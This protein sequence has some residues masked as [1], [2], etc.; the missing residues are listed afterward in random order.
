MTSWS[1]PVLPGAVLAARLSEDS[2]RSVM[3][4]EAGADYPAVEQTPSDLLHTWISAGPHDWGLVAKATADREIV[5]P[6][7]QG[8]RRMLRG[9]RAYRAARYA[10]GFRRMGRL[11]QLRS[12]VFRRCCR[13]I[14]SSK[15]IATRRAIFTAPAGRSG[16]NVRAPRPGSRSIAPFMRPRRELG[17]AEVWDHNDPRSTGVGPWPRNRRDG[18]RISTA[19]GYLNPARHRLNLT[20]AAFQP[21]P[22]A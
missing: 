20:D 21:I 17:Y 1:V 16:S 6:A 2:D 18:I 5:V 10:R 15:T 3:L 13:F 9:Q 19:I 8:H 22:I 12:G 4:L 14:A 7:R 11:G